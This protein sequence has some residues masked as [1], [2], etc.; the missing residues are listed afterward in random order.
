M[1]RRELLDRLQGAERQLL[2]TAWDKA[3]RAERRGLPEFTEFLD[4]GQRALLAG[5]R[6][7]W[8]VE[9]LGCGGYAGA[10]REVVAFVPADVTARSRGRGGWEPAPE[11]E[12]QA[13]LPAA[14]FPLTAVEAR[15]NFQFAAVSHRDY[16]GSLLALGLKRE[17]FGD[18]L[19]QDSC[20]QLVLHQHALPLVLN[21]WLSVGATSISLRQIELTEL[22]VPEREQLV[23]TA[24]VATLRLD[25]VLAVAYGCSRS[26]AAELI[27]AGKVKLNHRPE[28]R[29]DRQLEAGAMLS[30]AGSGR[31]EL[32]EVSGTSKSGRL[33]VKVARWQ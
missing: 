17:L 6:Y 4:P 20:C 31:A 27:K 25:A 28:T 3:E 14:Q 12:E 19:V 10:E 1:Q 2:A 15:G 18:I 30:L 23:R 22:Q 13:L 8:T 32:L 26:K 9:L 24:T 7:L 33:F 29:S 11:D 21:N 5:Y 16:L